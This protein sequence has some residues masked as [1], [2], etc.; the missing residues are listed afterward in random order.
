MHLDDTDIGAHSPTSLLGGV[1]TREQ[2]EK[3][4][5]IYGLKKISTF[6]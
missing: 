1:E 4:L 6:W 5:L 3:P 2:P